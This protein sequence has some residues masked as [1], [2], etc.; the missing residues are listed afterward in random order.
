VALEHANA[1]QGE[2]EDNTLDLDGLVG[3]T[4]TVTDADGDSV[5]DAIDAGVL[6]AFEDDGPG[7]E[8][9]TASLEVPISEFALAGFESYWSSYSGGRNVTSID[10]TDGA[11]DELQWGGGG[12][13]SQYR[14]DD[15]DALLGSQ[16]LQPDTELALGTFTHSNVT[17]PSGSGISAA[18]LTVSFMITI[19][20][21]ETQIDHTIEFDHEETTNSDD[22][23]ASRD[24][25][26][27][28]NATT[29][30]PVEVGGRV[31]E[32][33]ILGFQDDQG[34]PVSSTVYTNEGQ[35]NSLTLVGRL[36]STDEMPEVSGSIGGDFGADGPADVASISWDNDGDT[37][38]SGTIG[39][40]YGQLEVMADG[41]YTYSLDPQAR[42]D[43]EVGD[44]AVETFTYYLTDGD[45]D[46]V[47]QT[48][49]IDISGVAA[50]AVASDDTD[51]AVE[52]SAVLA[53]TDTTASA[54]WDEWT[55]E[56][57]EDDLV[58]TEWYGTYDEVKI[59]PYPIWGDDSAS[60]SSFAV[61]AD[62]DHP[63]TVSVK[64]DVDG[65]KSGDEIEVA[66]YKVGQSSPVQTVQ[67][68]SGE[69]AV[70]FTALT[71]GGSYYVRLYGDDNS[72]GKDLEASLKD[73]KVESYA[74]EQQKLET[75]VNNAALVAAL[76][77]SGNVLANDV[78]GP[79]GIELKSVN[80]TGVTAGG[81]TITG[82]YGD[83]VISSDGEYT[84]TPKDGNQDLPEDAT[85]T[86]EYT[87][88]DLSD[89][90]EQT[91]TLNIDVNDVDYLLDDSD[92]VALAQ[93]GGETLNAQ[94]GDDVL[95][96]SDDAD[97]LEGGSGNDHL[98]GEGGDD[99][100]IGGEGNDILIGGEGDDILTGGP[101]HDFFV[102]E[103][104]DQGTGAVPAMD[105][106]TD[107]GNGGKDTLDLADLLQGE[108]GNDLT[109]YLKVTEDGGN[110]VINVK[111]GGGSDDVSQVITLENTDLS[112]LGANAGDTQSEIIDSLISNGHLNVDS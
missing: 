47:T 24:V 104:G 9:A 111:P 69:T 55:Q 60:T 110:V 5:S 21:V 12:D 92:N 93:N 26:S 105:T 76:V 34:N 16:P 37:I 31:F 58:S 85:E 15:N 18:S 72:W 80:G 7:A 103:D 30:V 28:S 83:L 36:N 81:V 44:E 95:V 82:L 49:T 13:Y 109:Q 79:A 74:Y 100:L 22:P 54:T 68:G 3:V 101:G 62:N 19:D 25:I 70:T 87:I 84:Y 38:A 23:I 99:T 14:F 75:S 78:P 88:V 40:E 20:G 11:E 59:D 112:A 66:L 32:F 61:D 67:V 91:A 53:D 51:V 63:A 97:T 90:S 45:G 17:I 48:L 102:W 96:G 6:F 8:P 43:M 2:G 1:P 86:F 57:Y 52:Q 4:A 29:T 107:F 50:P 64:V 56:T 33:Q 89:N 10:G 106:V 98:I 42:A 39:G 65:Y 35:D 94:G 77:A 27:I 71:Q 46:T 108:E 73:L 41:S